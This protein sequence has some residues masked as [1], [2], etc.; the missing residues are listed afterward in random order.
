MNTEKAY[1]HFF[2]RISDLIELIEDQREGESANV[3][4]MLRSILAE[5][6]DICT[7]D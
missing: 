1:Y 4:W 7:A 5:A 6:E 2:R 3:L